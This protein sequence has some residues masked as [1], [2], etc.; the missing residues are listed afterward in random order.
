[1]SNE[2]N[3]GGSSYGPVANGPRA[4]AVQRDTSINHVTGDDAGAGEALLASLAVLREMVEQYAAQIPEAGKVRK[5]LDS[6]QSEATGPDADQP[7][8][9]DTVLRIIRRVGMVGTVLAAANDLRDL[10]ENLVH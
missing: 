6:I 4:R 3:I 8:M 1:V 2:I 7:A 5:D 9:R 10:I